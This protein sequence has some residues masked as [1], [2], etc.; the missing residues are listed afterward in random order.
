MTQP[1]ASNHVS[2]PSEPTAQRPSILGRLRTRFGL[3]RADGSQLEKA[4]K[5]HDAGEKDTAV[6]VLKELILRTD[7]PAD[8]NDALILQS[9]R[10]LLAEYQAEIG[11]RDGNADLLRAG[12][13]ILV[14]L[15][16]SNVNDLRNGDVPWNEKLARAEELLEAALAGKSPT[17]IDVGSFLNE[18]VTLA[19]AHNRLLQPE[20][21]RRVCQTALSHAA[22]DVPSLH[23]VLAE[24]E[25]GLGNH[26]N[27]LDCLARAIRTGIPAESDG[28]ALA[29]L[30]SI[31]RIEDRD[32]S[33]HAEVLT[34]ELHCVQGR[35]NQ[36]LAMLQRAI[37]KQGDRAE[38][39]AIRSLMSYYART[40][41]H[42]EFEDTLAVLLRRDLPEVVRIRLVREIEEM[43][44]VHPD[45]PRL[46]GSLAILGYRAGNTTHAL[47]QLTTLLVQHPDLAPEYDQ[48]L[49][50]AQSGESPAS[51]E[52]TS[53][54]W[55]LRALFD[56]G[57]LAACACLLGTLEPSSLQPE[58][59]A[60]AAAI[61][62]DIAAR[63]P[64]T[65]SHL[66]I[67]LHLPKP[68]SPEPPSPNAAQP[69]S[70]TSPPPEPTA[71]TTPTS[72]AVQAQ[73]PT[74]AVPAA[75][76]PLAC[77]KPIAAHDV[78]HAA[79]PILPQAPHHGPVPHAPSPQTRPAT[80]NPAEPAV[81]VPVAFSPIQPIA[82]GPPPTVSIPPVA[83]PRDET[84]PH[85]S[86]NPSDSVRLQAILGLLV[87][88]SP[89][90][91]GCA[92]VSH[93]GLLLAAQFPA[94]S[95][96]SLRTQI[97]A[98][99]LTLS[100]LAM[101][102]LRMADL[103]AARLNPQGGAEAH[104]G[105][106]HAPGEEFLQIRSASGL[107]VIFPA[108]ATASLVSFFPPFHDAHSVLPQLRQAASAL[109]EIFQPSAHWG[110][111]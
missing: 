29:L 77:A 87:M 26:H 71:V 73:V 84:H 79:A 46:R 35:A 25:F 61:A 17:P 94:A 40:R 103:A 9:A 67:L 99:V 65:G 39:G 32:I 105:H 104:A 92:V 33:E 6:S 57:A 41:R 85:D 56:A 49:Q 95:D 21:A 22:L 78:V 89:S 43:T 44:A 91:R 4:V 107:S 76:T 101:P 3:G 10:L 62:A 5:L 50:A 68:P 14:T 12:L 111:G 51:R 45:R 108:G 102:L 2:Q 7:P 109:S 36:G 80:P 18:I 81:I 8:A 100:Q 66:G 30:G 96:E 53:T 55:L 58:E 38:L 13:R 82:T 74:P 64:E 83:H 11:L 52:P 37:D 72:P 20:S 27:A 47:D 88:A 28:F 97:T 69:P 19:S 23:L 24:S 110:A 1:I 54:L 90:L 75:P 70:P 93:Q 60:K 86:G 63:L 16:K 34:A 15:P 59:A 98:A 48:L 31:Q 106:D 42:A